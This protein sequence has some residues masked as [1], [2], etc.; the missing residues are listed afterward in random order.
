MKK[1]CAV[2]ALLAVAAFALIGCSR[3]GMPKK[4]GKA[5]IRIGELVSDTGLPV[6]ARPAREGAQLALEEI[7][8][9]GGVLGRP[10]ELLTRD[11][12]NTPG[13]ATQ[14][15]QRL[16]LEDK[17]C[18][19]MGAAL[20]HV[21]L[22]V[23]AVA[24]HYRVPFLKPVSG[25][26]NYI[27]QRGHRYAFRLDASTYTIAKALAAEAAKNPAKRWAVV[28]PNYEYGHAMYQSF[29]EQLAKLRSDVVWV[30]E[31]SPAYGKI[32]AGATVQ[33]LAKE[34]PEALL[35]LLFS[36]DLYEFIRAGRQ[37]TFLTQNLLVVAPYFGW[38]EFLEPMG[39][40]TP[41]GWL[42][43][44][45]PP[46]AI[47]WPAHRDFA[48]KYRAKY[49]RD[50]H[51]YALVEYIAVKALAA[52]I[53]KAGSDDREKITEALRGLSLETPVG[54]ITFRTQDNQSDMGVWIGKTALVDG[55]PRMVDVKFLPGA[56]Y[57][58]TDEEVRKLRPQD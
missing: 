12:R 5:P 52:A 32:D 15:A 7:N 21:G 19:L 1:G 16:I 8:A 28:L 48:A 42:V 58:P 13:D 9:A 2:L 22:A 20:D 17:V 25:T 39:Q 30:A 11:D 41:Q 18:A 51:S 35:C 47:E 24:H 37:R 26:V 31:Q 56:D 50:P 43:H 53:E 54:R 57:M 40:E 55:K 27:W 14:A 49:G 44:G 36:Q 38:P 34:K 23:S 4:T 33:A 45:Y 29:K 46:Y 6:Q 10:L 3:S